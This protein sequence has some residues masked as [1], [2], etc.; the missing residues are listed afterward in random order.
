MPGYYDIG[1]SSVQMQQYVDIE[2]SGENTTVISGTIDTSTTGVVKSESHVEIRSLTIENRGGSG[3]FNT[4]A[5]SNNDTAAKITNVTIMASGGANNYGVYNEGAVVPILFNVTVTVS[6]GSSSNYGIYNKS[7]WAHMS[8]VTVNVSG[9][10][11]NY[12]IFNQSSTGPFLTRSSVSANGGTYN[13]GIYNSNTIINV[14]DSDIS[15]SGYTG[16]TYTYGI[17]NYSSTL[18]MR[19]GLVYVDGGNTYNYGI[20]NDQSSQLFLSNVISEASS[21]TDN[22]AL[23]NTS[24]GGLAR[25]NQSVLQGQRSV[26]NDS[27]TAT[28]YVGSSQL[29]GQVL[30]TVKCAGVY[31]SA[32][33]FYASSCP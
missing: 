2:G 19:N 1:T 20:L 12:G 28:L 18:S 17:Y 11:V 4:L 15:A 27:S 33:N 6:G 21:G 22:F 13:Y 30:G 23:F 24:T 29:V 3:H 26:R 32:Y 25:A 5:L 7:S 16:G 14:T 8:N 9:G 31:D 10:G